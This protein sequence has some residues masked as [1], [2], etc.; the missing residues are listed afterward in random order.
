MT[1]NHTVTTNHTMTTDHTATTPA[2]APGPV[3]GPADARFPRRLVAPMVLGSVLNPLNTSLLSV[4]LIPIGVAFG[5]PPSQTAWLVSALY[6][7]CAVGQPVTGRLVDAYG[8]RRLYLIGAA[9]VGVGGLLGAFAPHLGVLVAA[10]V[11]IGLGTCA[12][13][14]ASMS[15]IKRESARTGLSS[16]ASLLAALSFANQVIAVIGPSLGGLLVDLGGWRAVFTV[17]VPFAAACLALGAL[18]LPREPRAASGPAAGHTPTG[19]TP[20]GLTPS[21]LT[22]SGLPA[23]AATPRR[24]WDLA[25][26]GLFSAALVALML[27]LMAPSVARAWLLVVAAAAG[28]GFALRELRAPDPFLD[29]RVLGQNRPLLITY[30]RQ[31]LT[32]VVMYSVIYGLPQWLEHGRGLTPSQTGLI[33]L[34]MFATAMVG[35]AVTRKQ[36]GVLGRL[37]VGSALQ[38]IACVALLAVHGSTPVVVLCVIMA[39]FGLPQALNGLANQNALYDQATPAQIGAASGLFRTFMYLGALTSSAAT[40]SAYRD[41]ADT[42]GLHT[43]AVFAAVCAA[44]LLATV[45]TELALRR[46]RVA[47]RDQA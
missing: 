12:G 27:F 6:L 43:L 40:A 30:A 32:G 8:P 10:R 21:G 14:P 37:L 35:T 7:A 22:P 29:V 2:P 24:H 17:N 46:R 4:A 19:A 39:V 41:A 3:P 18:Y 47:S 36:R 26:I 44:L 9:M 38:L 20:P 11:L 45:V 15:L 23:P 28:A 34:P 33:L 31:L 1:T 25:G 5:A 16:P 42:A 13:Y